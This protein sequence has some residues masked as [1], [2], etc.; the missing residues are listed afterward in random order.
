MKFTVSTSNA[1]AT[2]GFTTFNDTHF[3]Y[4]VNIT[5]PTPANI[6]QVLLLVAVNPSS[7]TPGKNSWVG[8]D[9]FAQLTNLSTNA[10][11]YA[12]YVSLDAHVVTETNQTLD[13]VG[14]LEPE[15]SQRWTFLGDN[16]TK[17]A[18]GTYV[19]TVEYVSAYAGDQADGLNDFNFSK[20]EFKI[21]GNVFLESQAYTA[22]SDSD[23]SASIV[24]PYNKFKSFSLPSSALTTNAGILQKVFINLAIIATLIALIF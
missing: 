13:S 9:L 17:L 1:T 2:I 19:V 21:S 5:A 3:K 24:F 10:S 4:L 12:N 20:T 7:M 8:A 11:Q 22:E 23:E 15:A 16:F 14:S 6:D 18:D